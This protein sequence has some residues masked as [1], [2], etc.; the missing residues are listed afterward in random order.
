M[1]GLTIVIFV[2]LGIEDLRTKTISLWL[3]VLAVF[4]SIIYG[5]YENGVIQSL[6]GMLPGILLVGLS[7][8]QPEALGKGDG[9]IAIAYGNIYGWRNTCLWL[10]Y[11]FLL[12]ATI[13]L[14]ARLVCPK[15]KKQLPFI[16]FMG[17]VHMGMCL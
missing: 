16:P 9:L 1:K 4:G 8:L 13:G 15:S 17:I 11:S 12:V 2:L 14:F 3:I 6:I 7:F 5:V 10:M